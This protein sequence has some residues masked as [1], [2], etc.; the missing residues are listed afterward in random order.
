MLPYNSNLKPPARRLR[1]E[2][3]DAEQLLWSRLR[4]KQT[5]GVQ[6]YRQK[7]LGNFI[8]DFYAPKAKLVVEVDGSQHLDA[9]HTERDAER[10][11]YLKAQ[12]LRVLRLSNAEVLRK[13]D[14][15]MEVIH[16]AVEKI[17]P[18]PLL[19]RGTEPR[20]PI[21]RYCGKINPSLLIRLISPKNNPPGQK[22][23]RPGGCAITR[24]VVSL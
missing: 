2:L 12:G 3:T 17:P 14:A 21:N 10:D 16:R 4:R 15:V 20:Q 13:I 9:D 6:F 23:I 18:A 11:E 5:L 22:L 7:P 1:K 24:Q 8:V 19:P